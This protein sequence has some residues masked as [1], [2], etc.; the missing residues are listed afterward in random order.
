[1]ADLTVTAARLRPLEVIEA[2]FQPM[3]AAEAITKGQAVAYNA[4][5][6]AVL[7]DASAAGTAKVEGV[8]TTG[9]AAGDAFDAIFRGRLA[10]YD[11]SGLDAGESVYLSDTAGALGDVAGT[12]SVAVGRVVVMTDPDAT[13]ILF[14]DI[15]KN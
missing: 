1:M 15:R 8:A 7:A 9:A 10:G 4:A 5:G 12:V 11:L 6:Q 13:K 3:I 14:V 2:E